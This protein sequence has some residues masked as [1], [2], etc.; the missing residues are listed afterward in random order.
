MKLDREY[1]LT[2]SACGFE[3]VA[4]QALVHIVKGGAKVGHVAAQK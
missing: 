4:P 2:M 1:E 3:D